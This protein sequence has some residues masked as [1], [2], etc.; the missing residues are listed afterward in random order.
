MIA[1]RNIAILEPLEIISSLVNGRQVSFTYTFG[2]GTKSELLSTLDAYHIYDKPG[3]YIVQ[4]TA[5]NAISGDVFASTVYDVDAP[6][7]GVNFA[8]PEAVEVG[9]TVECNG[10]IFHGSRVNI[11]VMF[12]NGGHSDLM[13]SK[14]VFVF[15]YSTLSSLKP[16]NILPV[17]PKIKQIE[18]LASELIN[19]IVK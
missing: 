10:T 7:T 4:V 1:R 19:F 12:G 13:L 14:Q 11:T 3:S 5:T 9:H 6:V 16:Q 18:F 17:K 2:D 15:L 8:C